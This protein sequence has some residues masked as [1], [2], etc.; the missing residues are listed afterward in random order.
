MNIGVHGCAS[1][2]NGAGQSFSKADEFVVALKKAL[3]EAADIE[4]LFAIWERNVDAVRAINKQHQSLN[5]TR[6]YRSNLVSHMKGRAIALAKQGDQASERRTWQSEL[7][8]PQG[9]QERS[10]HSRAEAVP[11][12]GAFKLCGIPTLRHLRTRPFPPAPH[13]LCT[14]A[15]RCAESER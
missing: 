3:T 13:P 14:T 10:S 7:V 12:Q 5:A 15:R 4:Q 11:L 2:P 9:R 8:P 6:C 1:L